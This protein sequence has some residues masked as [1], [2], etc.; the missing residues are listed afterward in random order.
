MSTNAQI[1]SILTLDASWHLTSSWGI[2]HPDAALGTIEDPL[3]FTRMATGASP[4]AVLL[5]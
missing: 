2:P 3:T 5:L 4:D 1:G